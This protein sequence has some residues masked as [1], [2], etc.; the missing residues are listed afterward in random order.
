[1]TPGRR[2]LII[3]G[4][5]VATVG[6]AAWVRDGANE[7]ASEIIAAAP[8]PKEMAGPSTATSQPDTTRRTA[9]PR[10]E[11]SAIPRIDLEKLNARNPGELV[12]DPFAVPAPKPRK[13]VRGNAGPTTPTTPAPLQTAPP[14]PFT[15][16]GKLR[17]GADT[18]IFLTQGDR[19]LVLR[20]GDTI[21]SVYRVEHIADREITLVYLP[22]SQRQTIPIGEPP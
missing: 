3:G 2:W 5:L 21:D 4:L 1:M 12:R 10:G 8:G 6:A 22:L 11:R 13:I 20:E 19:N 18:A 17:S 9:S 15:Y 14:I 16:M 7:P